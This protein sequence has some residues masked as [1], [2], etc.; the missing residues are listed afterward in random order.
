MVAH[1]DKVSRAQGT[2]DR[3]LA[4]AQVSFDAYKSLMGLLEHLLPIGGGGR[5]WM[6]HLYGDNYRRGL[7]Q[8]PATVIVFRVLQHAPLRRW[9]AALLLDAGCAFSKALKFPSVVVPTSWQRVQVPQASV[10]TLGP[11]SLFSDAASEASS[12]GLGGWVHGNWWH[13]PLSVED[14]SI[15]HI[16]TLEFAA[17]AMNVIMFAPCLAGYEVFLYAVASTSVQVLLRNAAHSPMLQ[18][19]HEL[20]LA[21]PEYSALAPTLKYDHVF[22]EVNAFADAAS[23]DR[24]EVILSL[25]V[26]TGVVARRV[27]LS[28]AALLYFDELRARARTLQ[29]PRTAEELAAAQQRGIA[30]PSTYTGDGPHDSGG[31]SSKQP[32]GDSGFFKLIPEAHPGPLVVVPP[33]TS[34]G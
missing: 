19:A 20:L 27:P 7:A 24:P 2:I 23:R 11:Y 6:Y 13:L 21:S 10:S 5:P 26:Q 30:W 14:R 1:P 28:Q 22:G 18:S 8:G 3:A 9:L 31:P 25:A 4:G 29:R 15:M 33:S 17:A 34:R 12:G 32:K 16:T